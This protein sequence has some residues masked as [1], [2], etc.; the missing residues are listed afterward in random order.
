M[1]VFNHCW[2]R[3][4]NMPTIKVSYSFVCST[5]F[6]ALLQGFCYRNVNDSL[7]KVI[8]GDL[9]ILLP[10]ITCIWSDL[11]MMHYKSVA[12]AYWQCRTC[13]LNFLWCHQ[14]RG[15]FLSPSC[16]NER[17][18]RATKHWEH[19][20]FPCFA[21]LVFFYSLAISTVASVWYLTRFIPD[22]SWQCFQEPIARSETFVFIPISET[23][24]CRCYLCKVFV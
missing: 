3:H 5:F 8:Q 13:A 15:P 21:V 10:G 1:N 6:G 24:S 18:C 12:C 14:P 7:I 4:M 19:W 17:I 20:C 23:N 22:S 2:W 16:F 9:R 11:K